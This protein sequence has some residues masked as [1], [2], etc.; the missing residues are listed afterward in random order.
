MRSLPLGIGLSV[1]AALAVVWMV[2]SAVAGAGGAP[3]QA[4]AAD[5]YPVQAMAP[6]L[7]KDDEGHDP[8]PSATPTLTATVEPGTAITTATATPSA[9]PTATTPAATAT[10]TVTNTPTPEAAPY[11]YVAI[12]DSISTGI[13]HWPGFVGAYADHIENDTGRVVTVDNRAVNGLTS[14]EL[15]NAVRTNQAMR[16]ALRDA[17]VITWSIGGNDLRG[18]RTA[19]KEEE[20][21]GGDNQD[22][23]RDV[24]EQVADDWDDI[25]D[26]V[27]ALRGSDTIVRTM[28]IYNPYVDDD[29]ADGDFA[30]FKGYVD[31]LNQ[32]LR[33]AAQGAGIPVAGVY[34]AFNGAS[35][36]QDAVQYITFDGLHPDTGGHAVIAGLLRA[37]GYAPL[38]P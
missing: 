32:Q 2:A 11:R 23:L 29:K 17:D 22:C 31:G 19:Y 26:E 3:G 21:G 4:T 6:G 36:E 14:G 10:P 13:W 9:T 28:D 33:S 27:L 24:E 34:A 5:E 20:C 7:A 35:G 12:G 15:L 16:N 18:A 1:V 8:P 38:Y 37:F 30:V 25:I